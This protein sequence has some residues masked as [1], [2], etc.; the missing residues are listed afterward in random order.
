MG[1]SCELT[2]RGHTAMLTNQRGVAIRTQQPIGRIGRWRRHFASSVLAAFLAC[3]PIVAPTA[4][5]QTLSYDPAACA[6]NPG[7]VIYIAAIRL[8]LAIPM[9]E[10]SHIAD[11]PPS[12]PDTLVARIR[13]LLPTAPDPSEPEGCPGNPVQAQS[14]SFYYAYEAMLKNKRHPQIP[15]AVPEQLHLVSAPPDFWGLQPSLEKGL[16]W[17]CKGPG[18]H[19]KLPNGLTACYVRP[20]TGEPSKDR[21]GVSYGSEAPVYSAPLGRPF[22]VEC[23]SGG[24]NALGIRRCQVSYKFDNNLNISYHVNTHR[25]PPNE[26]IDFDR[27]LRDRIKSYIV[28]NF[29]WGR[30]LQ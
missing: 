25:V 2:L 20:S 22:V 18:I 16:S 27:N 9:N 12:K 17:S 8:V 10:L 13:E 7:D 11:Y 30:K 26:F 1:S 14:F 19:E 21:W 5:A 15:A 23:D 24:T 28:K 4:N 3:Q 29:D 6:A